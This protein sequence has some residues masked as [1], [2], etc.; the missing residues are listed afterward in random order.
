MSKPEIASRSDSE[1]EIA[2]ERLGITVT[3]EKKARG[4]VKHI[5]GLTEVL[6]PSEVDL[7]K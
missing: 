2:L 7:K 5:T 1:V 4:R 3:R 6:N